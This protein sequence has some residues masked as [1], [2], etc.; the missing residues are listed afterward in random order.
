MYWLLMLALMLLIPTL[1]G[2]Q[3]WR[4]LRRTASGDDATGQ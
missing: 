4:E 1:A 3:T 2:Y